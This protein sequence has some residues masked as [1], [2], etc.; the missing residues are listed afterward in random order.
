MGFGG[1]AP[2]Q[3]FKATPFTLAINM[4]GAYFGTTVELERDEHLA[5]FT[6]YGRSLLSDLAIGRLHPRGKESVA[7]KNWRKMEWN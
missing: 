1:D 3:L 2:K 7:S 6:S 4:T 5:N